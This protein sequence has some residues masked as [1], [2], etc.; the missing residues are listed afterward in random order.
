MGEPAVNTPAIPEH[1][2]EQPAAPLLSRLPPWLVLLRPSHWL[3]NSFV[4]AGLIFA[5]SW[6]D[7]PLVL[8]VAESF[9]A[10]CLM[11][12][13]VYALNDL[14]DVAVDRTHPK[15]HR[16]PLPA[17][18]LSPKAAAGIA[19]LC[20]LGG[21]ALA[22]AAGPKILVIV[23]AYAVLN[24]AYSL[25]LKH[26]VVLDVLLVVAGFMLRLA[27]G[28]MGVGIAPSPWLLL[29]GLLLTLFLALAKRR[30]ELAFQPASARKPLAHY[31]VDHLD[32]AIGVVAV[33]TALAYTLYTVAPGTVTLHKTRSLVFTVPMVMFGLFR[34][35]S[36]VYRR[37]R[38]EDPVT[39]LLRD[40]PILAAVL[41]W[42]ASVIVLLISAS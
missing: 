9:A 16:R 30:A 8:R 17:G 33:G 28:T 31:T 27:A 32:K 36:L 35:L 34:Y 38:G 10:F 1:P 22:A 11:A 21:L 23:S 42:T 20:L 39:D 41:L 14:L 15:K 40:G 13:F 3:K 12:S 37:G 6:R 5:H 7:I 24:V 26:I 29:C 18:T 25:G 19:A 2:V 4:F